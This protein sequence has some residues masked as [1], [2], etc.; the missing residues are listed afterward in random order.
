MKL[1]RT[2]TL[3]TLIWL[4]IV[5]AEISKYTTKYEALFDETEY[6]WSEELDK[7]AEQLVT[8][9]KTIHRDEESLKDGSNPARML[10]FVNDIIV[11]ITEIL[12]FASV[13][14]MGQ[15]LLETHHKFVE[16]QTNDKELRV[17]QSQIVRLLQDSHTFFTY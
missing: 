17:V 13:N 8:T 12:E 7:K 9:L 2:R 4:K 3:S 10:L 5:L 15:Q 11:Y 1:P 14:V 16:W 6:D